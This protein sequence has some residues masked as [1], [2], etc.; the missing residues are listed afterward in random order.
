MTRVDHKIAAP[1]KAPDDGPRQRAIRDAVSRR[2]LDHTAGS[3]SLPEDGKGSKPFTESPK[4]WRRQFAR[5][6]R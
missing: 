3:S 5:R 2:F 6:N 4:A 1:T